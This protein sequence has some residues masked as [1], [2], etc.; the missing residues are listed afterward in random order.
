MIASAMSRRSCRAAAG[1]RRPSE[2]PALRL[3]SRRLSTGLLDD[4]CRPDEP[5]GFPD[6]F[7][8]DATSPERSEDHGPN[9]RNPRNLAVRLG[10]DGDGFLRYAY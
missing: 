4:A 2:S 5:T 7:L 1:L 9:R 10:V 6:L 3:L 8:P